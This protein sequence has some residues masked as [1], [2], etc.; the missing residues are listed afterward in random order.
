LLFTPLARKWTSDAIERQ[1]AHVEDNSVKAAYS[2]AEYL[3]ERHLI[4]SENVSGI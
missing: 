2:Y 4:A 1:L 3:S